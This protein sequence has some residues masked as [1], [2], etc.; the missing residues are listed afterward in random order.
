MAAQEFSWHAMSVADVVRE[1]GTD[2]ER[3]LSTEEVKR[4]REQFGPNSLPPPPKPSVVMQILGQFLNPFVGTL[5]VAAG[6]AV[7]VAT[8]GHEPG[9]PRGL[10]RFS[11]AIAILTIVIVNAFIGFYQERKAEKALDALMKLS[12]DRC[13]V[14]RSGE[15]VHADARQLVPGDL[16]LLEAGDKVPADLRLVFATELQT[17][18]GE[19]TGESTAVEKLVDAVVAPE[20]GVGDQVTMAFS[21]TTVVH[22]EGRGVV[23]ATGRETQVGRVGKMLS[24][25]VKQQSP[26]EERLDQFSAQILWV[27]LALSAMLFVIGFVKGHVAWHVLLLTAV[28]VAVAVIPE[29]LPAITS[30]TLA[31]GMQRMAQRGAVVRKLA[32][33][34]TLGC[35]TVICTDKTGTLTLNEM[36]VRSLVVEGAAIDVTGEGSA[37]AGE[38]VVDGAK[39]EALPEAARRAVLAAVIAN[40][41]SLLRRPGAEAQLTGDPT[42]GALL[43]LGEK[44]GVH[45]VE[46]MKGRRELLTIPF[47][48]ARKRMTVVT[49]ESV[50]GVDAVVSRCKG[51][52]DVLLPLCTHSLGAGGVA[53]LDDA[54]RAAILATAE[55][56]SSRALRVLALAERQMPDGEV[57]REASERGF[58][59]LGLVG[60][61][62]P[63]RAEV[64]AAVEASR[65]AGIRVVMITG[66]HP[67]TAVAIAKELGLWRD[68]ARVITGDDLRTMD[69][70]ALTEALP[71]VRVFARV[72]PEHKLRIVQSL[73]ARGDVVAMTGDGVNDAPAIKQAAIGV[74]MGRGGTD[75]AREAAD[76]VLQD[77]NFATIVEAVREGRAI[78]RNIQKSIFFLLSS[79]AGLC[80]AVFVASFFSPRAVPPLTALQILWINLVTNGLPA[81]ALGVDPPE[82]GQMHEPPRAPDAPIMG[83]ADWVGIML[84]GTLMAAA[85]MVIY[86]LPIWSGHTAHEV[87]RS[88]LSMVFTLLALSPLAHAFNCRSRT[89]SIFRLGVFS[90]PLLVAAVVV[91]GAIH[92]MALMVPGLQPVFRTD[93]QWTMT[94][95]AVTVG[96]SLLPVPAIELV[97]LLKIGAPTTRAA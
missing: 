24:E 56:M 83:R 29:G 15:I 67:V 18:E 39:V 61:I 60:M 88:K 31:L 69:D 25:V 11:D 33:V 77:D 16:V 82:S 5:L 42:E 49:R 92:L 1:R 37:M 48:S 91:S 6:I 58:T 63:P 66:D 4:L 65:V 70:A 81:L 80:I 23:V 3:G 32:A 44:A 86:V 90:N 2:L 52:I 12:A 59:Y 45:R 57:D 55:A 26:L 21:G 74:A 62:D 40:T 87:E 36:T 50:D 78:Y 47:N 76:M 79:N 10:A 19:L 27:T 73:Q 54:G 38:F 34:E 13:K 64:R 85:A 89:A 35:A 51:A 20:A 17:V 84:V 96:L 94:E 9:A 7:G 28:S 71:L 95:V 46:A 30:I 75:V 68:D 97:K 14:R 53:P 43:V 22:G 8:M 72:D 41:A 93:H